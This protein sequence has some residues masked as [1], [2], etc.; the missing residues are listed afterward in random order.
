MWQLIADGRY[1]L[2]QEAATL[3]SS[4]VSQVA[5]LATTCTRSRCG[6]CQTANL[7][8]ETLSLSAPWQK[9]R[10]IFRHPIPLG[11]PDVIRPGT[12]SASPLQTRTCNV[13]AIHQGVWNT[14]PYL[15]RRP[16][17]PAFHCLGSD[18]MGT[19]ILVQPEG[20]VILTTMFPMFDDTF[21]AGK[22]RL[23]NVFFRLLEALRHEYHFLGGW[24]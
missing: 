1:A 3:I 8:E 22:V 20:K 12:G 18:G 15:R 5:F 2:L 23:R 16:L 13:R 4:C 21:N 7:P 6:N 17:S 9:C 14:R 19:R 11:G 24:D 10:Y